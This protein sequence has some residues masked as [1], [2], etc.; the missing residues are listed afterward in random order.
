MQLAPTT[1]EGASY[2]FELAASDT[3]A[4]LSA[5][6]QH[7]PLDLLELSL[8]CTAQGIAALPVEPQTVVLR[9]A[10]AASQVTVVKFVEPIVMEVEVRH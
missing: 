6:P 3:G 1:L 8:L 2:P 9:T 7:S 5:L 4:A 10:V